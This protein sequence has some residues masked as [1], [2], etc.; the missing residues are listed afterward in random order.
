MGSNASLL[1]A[2]DIS[3]ELRAREGV[4]FK[5]YAEAVLKYNI[6]G[7]FLNSLERSDLDGLFHTLEITNFI[8]KKQIVLTL[9]RHFHKLQNETNAWSANCIMRYVSAV[10][11]G[12]MIFVLGLSLGNFSE[13]KELY[14][15][16]NGSMHSLFHSPSV[17]ITLPVYIT[18]NS[19]DSARMPV[20][21]KLASPR[22]VSLNNACMGDEYKKGCWFNISEKGSMKDFICCGYDK[23][24]ASGSVMTYADPQII[25]YCGYEQQYYPGRLE[26]KGG[27]KSHGILDVYMHTQGCNCDRME[28]YLDVHPR[29]LYNWEPTTCSLTKWDS[30]LLCDLLG[31][32]TIL[33]IGDSTM[34]QVCR[35]FVNLLIRDHQN[36]TIQFTCIHSNKLVDDYEDMNQRELLHYVRKESPPDFVIFSTAAHYNNIT[37][38][39]GVIR[40]TFTKIDKFKQD[41][42][43]LNQTKIPQF[44]W[45]QPTPGHIGCTKNLYPLSNLSSFDVGEDK[46]HWRLFD[47]F[48]DLVVGESLQRYNVS[49]LDLTPLKYRP[50]AH[51]M[52]SK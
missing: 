25:P 10:L 33:M 23:S 45:M 13:T 28:G 20:L 5:G 42:A 40:E 29:E 19:S 12:A 3:C 27:F 9:E 46:Y 1:T 24:R 18:I 44:I 8:H 6:D 39:D 51:L 22:S 35:T 52:V 2:A 38:F 32:R 21:D 43:V 15:P 17:P 14:I 37:L 34:L 7:E 11:F 30:S 41:I 48:N 16:I 47:K 31:Y 26:Y 50:D 4:E 49:Y 36:C